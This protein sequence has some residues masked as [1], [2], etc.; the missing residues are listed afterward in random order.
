MKTGVIVARW[1]IDRLHPGHR[2]L[3]IEV[4]KRSDRLV[5]V[6]GEPVANDVYLTDKNPLDLRQRLKMIEDEGFG[7]IS[8]KPFEVLSLRDNPSDEVWSQN[9]DALLSG[10]E[11][12]VLYQSRD[13]FGSRYSGVHPVMLI[14]ET[15]GYSATKR[16]KEIANLQN[17]N[18]N[19]EFRQGIIYAI[20]KRFATAYSTVD[21]A[22]LK[23]H[24]HRTLLLLGMKHGKTDLVFPGGFVDPG[25]TSL[26]GAASRELQEEC[27]PVSHHEMKYVGSHK[28]PDSRYNGTKDGIITSFFA[29]YKMG[30]MERAGDDLDRIEWV[31]VDTFDINRLATH[32]HYLF[33]MLKS[34]LEKEYNN[35]HRQL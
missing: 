35:R 10:Y 31:D 26:E 15:V 11:D 2:D 29:T 3:I 13:G 16:R 22:L 32:H 21:I 5:I 27:G 8:H 18:M 17:V 1:Q 6:L 19:S 23:M 30:G 12:V 20:E 4:L 28:I 24:E 14:K 25:D 9:L 34:H 33:T 7:M